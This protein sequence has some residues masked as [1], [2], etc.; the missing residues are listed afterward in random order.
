MLSSP[1]NGT[2]GLEILDD[3]PDV[4]TI[5]VPYGGGGLSSGIAIAAKA[6]KPSIR[7]SLPIFICLMVIG[8]VDG[9][10]YLGLSIRF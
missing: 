2:I 8:E 4:D 7:V 10:N 6:L 9:I 1:G 3:L 5:I